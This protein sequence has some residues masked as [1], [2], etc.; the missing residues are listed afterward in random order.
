MWWDCRTVE[1]RA[2]FITAMKMQQRETGLNLS[3]NFF[4]E[5]LGWCSLFLEF[6]PAAPTMALPLLFSRQC[7]FLQLKQTPGF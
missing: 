7:F 4:L 2:S 3:L 5:L 1:N 6:V